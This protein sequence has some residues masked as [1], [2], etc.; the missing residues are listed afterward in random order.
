MNELMDAALKYAAANIAVFPIIP[1]DKKPLTANGFK[2]ATTDP[3]K[4]AEWWSVHPDA[5]VGIATGEMSGGL[6]AID[7]DIDKEKGKDGYRSFLK[8]CDENFLILPDS[9]LSITGRGG[10][11]LLYKSL[12]PVPSKIGWLEDVD[13]RANGGYIVAPPSIHPRYSGRR[14]YQ[15]SLRRP[16]TA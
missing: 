2:D 7:M 5:N 6:V 9:W 11:H 10:Y 15:S 4:I 8:W 13:I 3:E 12:F 16:D 14:I 1:R